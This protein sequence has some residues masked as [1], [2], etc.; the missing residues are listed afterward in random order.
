MMTDNAPVKMPK[1][2]KTFLSEVPTIVQNKFEQDEKVRTDKRQS[3][4]VVR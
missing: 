1:E 2:C 4:D 3:K